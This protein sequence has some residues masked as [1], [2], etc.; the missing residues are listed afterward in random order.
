MPKIQKKCEFKIFT[1]GTINDNTIKWETGFLHCMEFTQSFREHAQLQRWCEE[2]CTDKVI[3]WESH[4]PWNQSDQLYFFNQAD[5]MAC[6][7]RWI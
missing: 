7:L 1:K 2:N 3:Y 6:K 4:E 5:A